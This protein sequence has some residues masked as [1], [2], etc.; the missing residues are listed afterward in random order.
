MVLP[1]ILVTLAGAYPFIEAKM[2]KDTRQH[3]LLQRP[4]DVPVRTSL[5]AMAL[6][7]L[8]VD[9]VVII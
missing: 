5:G 4:R 1:G 8:Y 2:T 3:H 9:G 6:V 7:V